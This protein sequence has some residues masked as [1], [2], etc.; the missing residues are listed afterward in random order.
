MK[1]TSFSSYGK[2]QVKSW[3]RVPY[4]KCASIL[5]LSRI[6]TEL[7]MRQEPRH[8]PSSIKTSQI[9]AAV[10][11]RRIPHTCKILSHYTFKFLFFFRNLFFKKLPLCHCSWEKHGPYHQYRQFAA[12]FLFIKRNISHLRIFRIFC[13]NEISIL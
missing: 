4:I 6:C 3:K 9:D 7:E 10:K 11:G 12:R 5:T 1:L 13:Q 8:T 2:Y